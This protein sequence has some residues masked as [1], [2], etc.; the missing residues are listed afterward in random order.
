MDEMNCP[1]CA[2]RISAKD[3]LA[4]GKSFLLHLREKHPEDTESADTVSLAI[5]IRKLTAELQLEKLR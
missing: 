2:T 3:N 1:F 4:V 5:H